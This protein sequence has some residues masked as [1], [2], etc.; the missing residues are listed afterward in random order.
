ME[1]Q[2]EKVDES[3]T[4]LQQNTQNSF[5]T[6]QS[7]TNAATETNNDNSNSA[8]T[9]DAASNGLLPLRKTG[10]AGGKAAGSQS[11]SLNHHTEGS[12]GGPKE[13]HDRGMKATT[14]VNSEMNSVK[15]H[16]DG[17]KVPLN[18]SATPVNGKS[19]VKTKMSS[20]DKTTKTITDKGG[21]TSTRTSPPIATKR[22][23][24]ASSP[25]SSRPGTPLEKIP[26]ARAV[27]TPP[28]NQLP[29]LPPI[30]PKSSPDTPS[31]QE[32][33]LVV[34]Q[35]SKEDL[36]NTPP[37]SEQSP[38][39][40]LN[41]ED[42]EKSTPL[43]PKYFKIK[44]CRT[45]N[46]SNVSVAQRLTSNAK[47]NAINNSSNNGSNSSNNDSNNYS[48]ND[49][50]ITSN[51]NSNISSNN[52]NNNS[53]NIQIITEQS[54]KANSI[55][56]DGARPATS[57]DENSSKRDVSIPNSHGIYSSKDRDNIS[58]SSIANR[59]CEKSDIH[60][61]PASSESSTNTPAPSERSTPAP[62]DQKKVSDLDPVMKS[63]YLGRCAYADLPP[64]TKKVVRIFVSSTFSGKLVKK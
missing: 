55:T 15:K 43:D 52:D 47:Q 36:T 50:N 38:Q 18:G 60:P 46:S 34:S 10:S 32:H 22:T 21:T 26:R 58:S 35:N 61:A 39:S 20:S 44:E 12:A 8:S 13:Q 7:T 53:S 1:N 14:K 11:S 31:D 62:T 33:T 30:K 51:N 24:S 6:V 42:T 64:L 49:S 45:N 37:G 2:N 56:S 4:N 17:A 59:E 57:G 27:N 63:V 54:S 19:A 29:P 28:I 48:N 40:P 41:K 16:T 3:K 23:S 5:T 25:V 9:S